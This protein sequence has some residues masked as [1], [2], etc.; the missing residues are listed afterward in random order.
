MTRAEAIAYLNTRYAEQNYLFPRLAN[1]IS[2]H[3]YI[4]ANLRAAM[5]MTNEDS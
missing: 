1:K 2:R 3:D 5:N 4:G